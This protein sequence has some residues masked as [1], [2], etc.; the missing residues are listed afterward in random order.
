MG[1]RSTGGRSTGGRFTGGDPAGSGTLLN[2][3]ARGA[4]DLERGP[5]GVTAFDGANSGR[6]PTGVADL[7]PAGDFGGPI[8]LSRAGGA[9]FIF[10]ADGRGC[11]LDGFGSGGGGGGGGNS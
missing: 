1:G 8:I 4:G 3:D 2:P 5:T 10:T 7:E 9:A 6:G 11:L